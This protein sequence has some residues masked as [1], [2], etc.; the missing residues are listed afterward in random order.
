MLKL[1]LFVLT[2]FSYST[3][4]ILLKILFDTIAT[5]IVWFLLLLEHFFHDLKVNRMYFYIH[6][7]CFDDADM[8]AIE[9]AANGW[10][11]KIFMQRAL[12]ESIKLVKNKLSKYEF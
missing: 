4:E 12:V 7:K 9:G 1:N 2:I 10:W 8:L 6:R 5:F 11:N 3:Y